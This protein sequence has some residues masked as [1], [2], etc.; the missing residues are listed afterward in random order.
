MCARYLDEKT[1]QLSGYS[2]AINFIS[3]MKIWYLLW[4]KFII[5]HRFCRTFF[6]ITIHNRRADRLIYQCLMLAKNTFK[7]TTVLAFQP[8]KWSSTKFAPSKFKEIKELLSPLKGT[9][10]QIWKSANIFVFIWKYYVEDFIL[11]PLLLFEICARKISEK[12]VYKHSET[13]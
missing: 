7:W 2:L 5:Y 9:L 12:F 4:Q 10:M 1:C 6:L 8:F 11:K 13:E 3:V